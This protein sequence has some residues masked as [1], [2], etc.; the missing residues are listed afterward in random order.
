[1]YG[2]FG[3]V[4]FRTLRDCVHSCIGWAVAGRLFV[5]YKLL[6]G[7]YLLLLRWLPLDPLF[8]ISDIIGLYHPDIKI[9]GKF[10]IIRVDIPILAD[11]LLTISIF[12]RIEAYC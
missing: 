2:W 8:G 9:S 10:E 5:R 11:A 3:W 6:L 12:G 1:M 4:V 7:V